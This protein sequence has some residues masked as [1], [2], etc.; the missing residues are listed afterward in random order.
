MREGSWGWEPLLIV[1]EDGD[2]VKNAFY[3]QGYHQ[4]NILFACG[5]DVELSVFRSR[6]KSLD[7]I[8]VI[9]LKQSK[10][11]VGAATI[12]DLMNLLTQ[13]NAQSLYTLLR[14]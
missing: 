12:V 3:R 10:A 9:D 7:F 8:V 13:W 4:E 5:R 1:I 14:N 11:V 2:T 6:D